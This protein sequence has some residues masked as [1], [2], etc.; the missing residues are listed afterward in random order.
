MNGVSLFS[1]L[2]RQD[3]Q[4][5]ERSSKVN[6]YSRPNTRSTPVP[7]LEEQ[8]SRKAD[9]VTE[10]IILP[11]SERVF[12]F[13]KIVPKFVK[14]VDALTG[15][16]DVYKS[17]QK[18]IAEDG[19]VGVET[20]SS[21]AR[22]TAKTMTTGG[23]MYSAPSIIG[24]ATAAAGPIGFVG[25]VGAVGLGLYYGPE[26]TASVA[27]STIR[28]IDT[29]TQAVGRGARWSYD[30]LVDFGSYVSH[31]FEQAGEAIDT[32]QESIAKRKNY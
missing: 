25:G 6:V 32:I 28:G 24:G 18:D 27:D 4:E 10:R 30:K 12:D 15:F 16:F 19:T 23:I 29:A 7:S 1:T 3:S 9:N 22:A 8:F 26:F 13:S 5:A 14:G 31:K 21:I 17:S 2:F 11:L 20:M